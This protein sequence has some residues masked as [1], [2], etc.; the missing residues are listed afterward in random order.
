M[1][2]A[3]RCH[4]RMTDNRQLTFSPSNITAINPGGFGSKWCGQT[5]V[6]SLKGDLTWTANLIN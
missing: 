1:H 3:P 2:V 5:F 6:I 4:T